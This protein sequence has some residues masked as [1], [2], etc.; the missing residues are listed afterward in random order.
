MYKKF[1]ED[2]DFERLELLL[3]KPNIFQALNIEKF[4]LRHSS[5]LRWL[6]DPNANHGLGTLF[7]NRFLREIFID[8]RSENIS[9]IDLPELSLED[10]TVNCE[11]NNVDILIELPTIVIA[12]ENK[13]FSGEHSN[14]LHSYTHL[15]QEYFQGK[16]PVFVFLTPYGFESSLNE[17]YI[18]LGY[19]TIIRILTDI[20][21][22]LKDTINPSVG[23]YINDYIHSVRNTIMESGEINELARRINKNHKE[24]L[25]ILYEN[26]PDE[27]AAFK[28]ALEKKVIERGWI[29]GSTNKGFVR[30][31][32]PALETIIPK[33]YGKGWTLKE[34]FLFEIQLINTVK[35]SIRICASIDAS[36]AEAAVIL[37]PILDK[38]EGKENKNSQWLS[39]QN[40][41]YKIDIKKMIDV[42]NDELNK[43][44]DQILDLAEKSNNLIEP[45]IKTF[46]KELGELIAKRKL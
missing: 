33:G 38:I 32:T 16:I 45:Q 39:Y 9:V 29:L 7:L 19:E 22:L 3:Q 26:R 25:E 44:L 18:N 35:N 20:V 15:I 23:V 40:K 4:E 24:L 31:L 1:I 8:S 37:K 2:R 34:S 11:W 28:S 5:F 46:E 21:Q 36:D 14:Q 30:Y 6:L 17:L 10:A 43:Q 27:T 42:E 41:Y 12:I 13:V